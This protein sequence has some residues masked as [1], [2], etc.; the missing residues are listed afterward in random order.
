M[1]HEQAGRRAG[2]ARRQAAGAGVWRKARGARRQAVAGVAAVSEGIF[3][4]PDGAALSRKQ[5]EGGKTREW[6]GP[7]PLPAALAPL[8]FA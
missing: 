2:L 5:A 3:R 7:F 6:Y 8:T 4:R 1:C